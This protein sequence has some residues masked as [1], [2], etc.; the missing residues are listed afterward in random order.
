LIIAIKYASR[1]AK[2]TT[3]SLVGY[4][5]KRSLKTIK[6]LTL[7]NGVEFAYHEKMSGKLKAKIYFCDPYKSW[8]KGAIENAN[9]LYR[10]P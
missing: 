5:K 4:L 10:V 9:K 1:H 3:D 7:D 8:Q 2:T 6:T